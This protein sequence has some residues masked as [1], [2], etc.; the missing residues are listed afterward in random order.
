MAHSTP[1]NRPIF[2]GEFRHALDNKN[3]ITIPSRWREEEGSEFFAFPNPLHP[4]LTVMWPEVFQGLGSDAKSLSEPAKR[5]DFLRHLYSQAQNATVDKQGR[6]LLTDDHCRKAGLR[7]ELV[8]AGVLDRFE[9]WSGA[10]WDK[11]RA[12]EKANYV[13]VAKQIGL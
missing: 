1:P 13:E 8:L 9:I 3:R 2:S 10:N 11:F 12:A 7:G 4:C 5:Q 6:L